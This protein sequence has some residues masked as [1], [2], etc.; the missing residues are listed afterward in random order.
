M[1]AEGQDVVVAEGEYL[2]ETRFLAYARLTTLLLV[3]CAVLPR[4]DR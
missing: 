1:H 2:Q 4:G 3:A